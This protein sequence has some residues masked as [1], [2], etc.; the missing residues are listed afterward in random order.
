MFRCLNDDVSSAAPRRPMSLELSNKTK[1]HMLSFP[2]IKRSYL[3]IQMQLCQ[4]HSLRDWLSQKSYFDRKDQIV[5]IFEQIVGAVEYVHLKGLI[6]R[7]LKPGNIFFSLDGQIKI[8]DFGLVTDMADEPSHCIE[9]SATPQLTCHTKRVGT[10]L[11]MSPEQIAGLPY[12]YKVDIYS[13]GLILFELYVTF[14]TEMERVNTLKNLRVNQFP[15]EFQQRF[16]H[17]HALLELMLSQSPTNR[18]TT[19]GIRARPPLLHSV[20]NEN[21]HFELPP[22][23]RRESVRN[24]SGV[25]TEP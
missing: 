1:E 20:S 5:P 18:P 8:G 23:P 22:R 11:Y 7:D 17:V 2:E 19:F 25:S 3:Y 10:H 16:E 15:T 14:G 6:H 13:L 12:N 24:N 9:R 4:K 21:W